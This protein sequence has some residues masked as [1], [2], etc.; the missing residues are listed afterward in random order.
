MLPW[1]LAV[2]SPLLAAGLIMAIGPRHG[3]WLLVLAPLPALGVALF[4]DLDLACNLN[5]FLLGTRL[6]FGIFERTFVLLTVLAWAISALF[7]A[8]GQSRNF[9]PGFL[10]MFALTMCGNIGLTVAQDAVSFYTFFALMT[11]A[12]YILV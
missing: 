5:G 4:A 11:F 2:F 9:T 8:C 7:L 6:G 12:A 1:L 10:S 3:K